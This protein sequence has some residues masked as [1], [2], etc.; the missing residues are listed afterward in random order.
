[1]RGARSTIPNSVTTQMFDPRIYRG[2]MVV[3]AFTVIVFGF[4]LKSQPPPLGT[5]IAPGQFF[6]TLP[7]TMSRPVTSQF[8]MRSMPA[9]SAERASPQATWSCLAIPARG[10][11][12]APMTG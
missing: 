5:T 9:A 1:M 6:T 8:W 12:V 7:S 2:F 3:V 4:S 10:W 11:Y